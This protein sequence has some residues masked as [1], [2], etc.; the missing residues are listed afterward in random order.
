MPPKGKTLKNTITSENCLSGQKVE[1]NESSFYKRKNYNRQMKQKNIKSQI[2]IT[3]VTP[4]NEN[5][6]QETPTD[7]GIALP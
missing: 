5:A 7:Q 3:K 4:I 1:K 2:I 6:P